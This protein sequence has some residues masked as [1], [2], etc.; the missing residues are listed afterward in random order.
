MFCIQD[1]FRLWAKFLPP[2]QRRE[3]AIQSGSVLIG[4]LTLINTGRAK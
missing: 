1:E 4:E 2:L 3:L